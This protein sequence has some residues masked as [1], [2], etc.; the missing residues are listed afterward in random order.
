MTTGNNTNKKAFPSRYGT[1]RP[2]S[3]L[4]WFHPRS[5]LY[6]LAVIMDFYQ[7]REDIQAC[8]PSL[9]SGSRSQAESNVEAGDPSLRSG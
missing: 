6:Q 4:S 9:R 1:K 5:A 2:E 8:H 3:S 7:E